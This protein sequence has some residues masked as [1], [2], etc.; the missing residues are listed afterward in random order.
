MI[1]ERIVRAAARLNGRQ[2]ARLPWSALASG[3]LLAALTAAYN[4]TAGPLV[5]LNDIGTWHNRLLFGA[6]AGF[7][8]LSLLLAAAMLCR[9]GALRAMLRQALVT[10]GFVMLLMGINQKTYA[11]VQT[12]QPIVR[13][14]DEAGLSAA[15]SAQTNLTAPALTLLYLF[16]RGPVYDMYLVKLFAV[17]CDLTLA[18]F[19]ARAAEEYGEGWR[20]EAALTLCLILPQGFLSAGC[21]AEFEHAAALLMALS[22]AWATGRFGAAKRPLCAALCYGGAAALSGVALYALPLYALLVRRREMRPRDLLCGAALALLL[23]VPAGACGMGAGAAASL[24]RACWGVPGYASGAPGIVWLFPRAAVEE[25]PGYFVLG[26]LP[27][28][29]VEA[30]AQPYYT[31]AHM[32]I[33]VRSLTLAGLALLLCLWAYVL[34][35]KKDS[36]LRRALTLALGALLLC[37]NATASAWLPCCMLCVLAALLE[38]GLRGSACLVLF[39]TACAC[40][41]PVTGEVLL[42]MIAASALCAAALAWSAGA[43]CPRG[44]EDAHG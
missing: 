9:R 36:P 14:M 1:R 25:M 27:A 5:N 39:A 24:L 32:E 4:L 29:D 16:T 22:L 43:L 7:V 11:Y 30:G 41:A 8:H 28:L 17:A 6:M 31:Q 42:P 13:A 2:D 23:C 26:R 18:L 20:A 10:A 37:P 19:A 15:A 3:V 21:A 44:E 34:N 35:K 33:A 40:A 38:P 12:V